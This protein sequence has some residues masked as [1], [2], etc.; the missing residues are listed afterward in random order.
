MNFRQEQVVLFFL[1][2]VSTQE[3]LLLGVVFVWYLFLVLQHGCIV[4]YRISVLCSYSC[5][6]KCDTDKTLKLVTQQA[7]QADD[8]PAAT[9]L[10]S[11]ATLVH[12]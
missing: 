10:S 6:N 3:Q 11:W 5:W 7:T 9:A 1:A 8:L 12:V 4:R 2:S